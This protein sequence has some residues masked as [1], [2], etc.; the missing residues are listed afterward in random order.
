MTPIIKPRNS[1]AFLLVL[2][3]ALPAHAELRYLPSLPFGI[4]ERLIYSVTALGIG[5]G[6]QIVVIEK[7]QNF[8]GVDVVVGRVT[9]TSAGFARTIYKLDDTEVTFFRP[10]GI[11]PVFYAKWINEGSWHDYMETYYY[12]GQPYVEVYSEYAGVRNRVP[13]PLGIK[14][15]FTLI[16]SLRCLDYEY[17]IGGGRRIEMPYLLGDKV[18]DAV[19]EAS[20]RREKINGK[21]YDT[22]WVSE[23]GGLKSQFFFGNAAERLPLKMII[24]SYNASGKS[25][26]M[27]AELKEYTLGTV[28]IPD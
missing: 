23:I 7:R 10:R 2:L 5:L 24:P 21:F 9:M 27:E 6:D 18:F 16:F 28:P 13:A 4:G 25:I 17:Y 3:F 1:L 14:N 11:V 22:I 20:Y 26:D 12:P 8:Q 15:I 19:F